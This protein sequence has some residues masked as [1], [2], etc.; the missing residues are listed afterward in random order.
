MPGRRWTGGGELAAVGSLAAHQH[1]PKACILR[2]IRPMRV[3]LQ[4]LTDVVE[5]AAVTR[6]RSR[7]GKHT[8]MIGIL[9]VAILYT[10]YSPSAG[11]VQ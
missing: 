4:A 11:T 9:V 8:F 5:V 1:T 3:A 10:I 6:V 2:W 7:A